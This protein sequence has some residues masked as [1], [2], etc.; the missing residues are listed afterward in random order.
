MGNGSVG[1]ATLGFE[2]DGTADEAFLNRVLHDS[3][4]PARARVRGKRAVSSSGTK[5]TN[6]MDTVTT[7]PMAIALA[8][9]VGIG[10][11][12]RFLPV[13]EQAAEAAQ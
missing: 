6:N 8:R 4:T 11:I 9:V 2:L 5:G 1:Q 12:H 13:A 3:R 10:V 7:A